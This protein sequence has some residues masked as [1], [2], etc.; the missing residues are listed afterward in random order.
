VQRRRPIEFEEQVLEV[1]E[2]WDRRLEVATA[3]WGEL[4]RGEQR[5]R[6]VELD[7][8]GESDEWVVALWNWWNEASLADREQ[9]HRDVT[10]LAE[11]L[12]AAA[13]DGRLD[14]ASEEAA[15]SRH[16]LRALERMA[17]ILATD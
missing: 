16:L 4:T 3:A 7:A 15:S 10:V 9:L 8:A 2:R 13:A 11:A 17:E 6:E 1:L 14:N 12:W 5:R